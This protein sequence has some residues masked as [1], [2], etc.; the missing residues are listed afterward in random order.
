MPK[1][2]VN[3]FKYRNNQHAWMTTEIF[4]E[5]LNALN[6]K[7]KHQKRHILLFLD[8]CPSHLDI[9]LSN[10]KPHFIPKNTTSHLPPL[11][12]GIIA[13]LKS[14]Y[15][16]QLMTEIRRAMSESS[17]VVELAKKVIIYDAIVN[18]TDG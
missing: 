1:P 12:K 17:T 8:N 5:F 16:I 13:R 11:D 2:V 7:M 9:K 6:N 14:F 15:K 18:V 4:V 10:V 3:A